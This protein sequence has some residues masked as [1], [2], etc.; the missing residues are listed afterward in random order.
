MEP[1]VIVGALG[2]TLLALLL[3]AIVGVVIALVTGVMWVRE[4]PVGP[5]LAT[6]AVGLPLFV[7]LGGAWVKLGALDA[8][9]I[10]A[11]AGAVG[12]R[13]ITFLFVLPGAVLLG[14][15]GAAVGWR[16]ARRRWGAM[17]G[18]FACVLLTAGVVLAGGLSAEDLAYPVL[19]AAIYAGV[20]LPLALAM[21]R[22][23]DAEPRESSGGL[24]AASLGAVFALVVGAGEASAAALEQVF[25]LRMLEHVEPG[26]RETFVVQ[27]WEEVVAPA[28][29]W[30][31]ATLL[32]ATFTGAAALWP[33]LWAR[34][35]PALWGVAWV[36]AAP[37][38]AWV[39]AP[40]VLE[41][42]A[43]AAAEAPGEAAEH[44]PSPD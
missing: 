17:A 9:A 31:A 5:H 43:L 33:A 2:G 34:R 38:I 36:L 32:A 24:A 12:F 35:W 26:L 27:A 8:D 39:G 6:W 11:L 41:L 3:S 42:S 25:L 37:W 15:F 20:G 29:R 40:G 4:H 28:A 18:S 19:R 10:T 22:G 30:R 1:V 13:L 23:A 21:L 44:A 16:A 7:G 14:L